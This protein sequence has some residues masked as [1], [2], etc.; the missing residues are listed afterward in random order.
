MD[1]IEEYIDYHRRKRSKTKSDR[2]QI[3]GK[4]R[5]DVGKPLDEVERSDVQDWIEYMDGTGVK[6]STLNQYLCVLKH[7][8]SWLSHELPSPTNQEEMREV[9]EKQKQFGKIQ[10]IGRLEEEPKEEKILDSD[11]LVKLVSSARR[12]VHAKVWVFTS[13]FGLRRDELRLL[14]KDL[15]DFEN[16]TITVIR[17]MTK[18]P[19]GTR[20]IPFHPW[21][22]RLLE[23]SR[24]KYVLGGKKPYSQSFFHWSEYDDVLDFH[25]TTHTFRR[26]YNTLMR[27]ILQKKL[28]NALGDYLLKTLMG[29]KTS[30][31]DMSEHYTGKTKNFEDDKHKAQT[32]WHYYNRDDLFE[33]LDEYL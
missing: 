1:L 2:R 15:V 19:A 17:P 13:Y 21:I 25:F 23:E 14:T 7:F 11:D 22:G 6:A 31:S 10:D 30:G 8:Y 33:R 24:G 12:R 29:H 20:E 18:T 26:T 32:D 28:G 3:L 9:F 16:S 5:E 4:F 27:P